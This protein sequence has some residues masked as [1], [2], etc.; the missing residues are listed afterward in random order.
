MA[1]KPIDRGSVNDRQLRQRTLAV[2]R[3]IAERLVSS[4][5]G[6]DLTKLD[7]TL[8]FA[9]AKSAESKP[10]QTGD[11]LYSDPYSQ[12]RVFSDYIVIMILV[13]RRNA[14]LR[15]D[16]ALKTSQW[17]RCTWTARSPPAWD[18]PSKSGFSW[19]GS[20]RHPDQSQWPKAPLL[21]PSGCC[22]RW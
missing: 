14:F 15:Q 18:R 6:L 1:L 19:P 12:R 17:P 8:S 10:V 22:L 9:C 3:R 4:L 11:Q 20:N 5:T 7:N 13:C 2:G 21:L 16:A